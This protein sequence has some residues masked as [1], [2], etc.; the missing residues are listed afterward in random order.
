MFKQRISQYKI[1]QKRQKDLIKANEKLLK[2]LDKSE[3][4]R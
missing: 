1:L 4:I 3:R 2:A